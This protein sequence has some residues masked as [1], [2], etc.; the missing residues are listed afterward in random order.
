MATLIAHSKDASAAAVALQLAD[1][2]SKRRG[3]TTAVESFSRGHRYVDSVD[4]AIVLA[5]VST[6]K[7]DRGTRNFINAE[8]A[9]LD[10]KSL[11]NAALGTE[12]ELK[13]KQLSA[14]TAF[15]PRDTA[16]FRSDALEN[17]ALATWVS[18]INSRGAV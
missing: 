13:E 6:A 7:I 12:Q 11:F 14:L 16:Y 1:T 3:V 18:V 17:A 9:E 4:A 10:T 15:E 8:D 2:L 5:P